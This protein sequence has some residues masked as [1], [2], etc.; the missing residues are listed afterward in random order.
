MPFSHKHQKREKTEI[1]S[2]LR[3]FPKLPMTLSKKPE[4]EKDIG[5]IPVNGQRIGVHCLATNPDIYRLTNLLTSEECDHL[6]GICQNR[7]QR[8]PA[9]TE[10]SPT[11]NIRTSSSAFLARSEDQVVENLED[12]ISKL[13]KIDSRQ[14]EPLQIVHY[15]PGQKYEYHTDWFDPNLP[16]EA[17]HITKQMGGQRQYTVLIYLNDLLPE[18]LAEDKGSTCFRE[19][20][21]CAKPK[22]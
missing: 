2:W 3:Q 6:I 10:K 16:Y 20:A 22:R 11:S 13:L 12:R 1:V 18:D 15:T 9:A 14:I 19:A 17:K 7:F 8:S 5:T 21:I 4:Q